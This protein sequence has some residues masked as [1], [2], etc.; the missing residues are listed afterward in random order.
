[1]WI[2]MGIYAIT[3]SVI[4]CYKPISQIDEV[5]VD[6]IMRYCMPFNFRFGWYEPGWFTSRDT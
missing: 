4:I 3:E 1:M 2:F 6:E 5:K